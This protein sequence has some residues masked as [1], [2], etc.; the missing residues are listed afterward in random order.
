MS[1]TKTKAPP[2]KLTIRDGVDLYALI[3]A[4]VE[5]HIDEIELN[6]GAMPYD[7]A[8][9]LDE[10][11]A[12]MMQRVDAFAAKVDE[13]SGYAATAKATKD[14]AARREKVWSNVIKSMKHYGLLQVQRNAGEPL[15]GAAA[16]LRMQRNGQPSI[17]CALTDDEL[18]FASECSLVGPSIGDHPL[19]RFIDVTLAVTLDKK[20]LG[21][22]YEARRIEL[23]AEAW[24]LGESDARQC[25][26]D[27]ADQAPDPLTQD[28]IDATLA[29]MRSQYIAESLATE[30]PGVVVT[31]GV[32]L[33]ID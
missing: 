7:L 15:K 30:F 18:I 1:A 26:A 16:T 6:E 4:Y 3:N 8:Q 2:T 10:V 21:T 29:H 33:R 9:L 13:F 11:D 28:F 27:K 22:A 14:R 23:E 17:E 12:A 19:G 20:A 31:R 25:I 24:L 5:E 32:H